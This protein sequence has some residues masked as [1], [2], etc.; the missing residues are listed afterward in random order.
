MILELKMKRVIALTAILA[1]CA[2]NP[3][4]PANQAPATEA[5][6]HA[7]SCQSGFYWRRDEQPVVTAKIN[8]DGE[9]GE[10]TAAGQTHWAAYSV[11]GFDRRWDFGIELDGTFSYALKMEPSGET[12]YYD[13]SNAEI[14]ES[15]PVDQFFFCRQIY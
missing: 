2:S 6:G 9:T 11:S 12:R 15:V 1:G 3:H 5:D 14:G 10:I 8:S 13:F 7:F 4:L